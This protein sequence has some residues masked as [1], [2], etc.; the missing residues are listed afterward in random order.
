M[1]M[2]RRDGCYGGKFCRE[3]RGIRLLLGE[4][5]RVLAVCGWIGHWGGYHPKNGSS[6]GHGWVV[7]G[8]DGQDLGGWWVPGIWVDGVGCMS[9]RVVER[10]PG[11]VNGKF[12]KVR[13][14]DP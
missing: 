5:Q 9:H 6:L 10:K 12:E 14:Y 1:G 13:D 7:A 4:L 3:L 2:D 11:P 8:P